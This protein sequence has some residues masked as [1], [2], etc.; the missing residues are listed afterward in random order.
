V[1]QS[2]GHI[3]AYS[4]PGIGSTFKV[5]FPRAPQP[6]DEPVTVASAPVRD[7]SETL[8]LV[9]DDPSVSSVAQR[10]LAHAGYR[11]LAAATPEA[12]LAIESRFVEPIDLLVTDVVMPGMGGRQVADE[13]R[14][15]RPGLPVLYVSGYTESAIAQNGVVDA[16]TWFLPK[17]FTGTA[18]AAKV[19]EVLDAMKPGTA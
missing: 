13:L 15:R 14:R 7:G 9:E 6:V 2:G 18:L 10:F 3:Y 5:Y 11:V 12:A 1:K 4:E 16:G 17:P 8:L 19:R